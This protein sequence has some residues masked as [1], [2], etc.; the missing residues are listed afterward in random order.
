MLKLGLEWTTYYQVISEEFSISLCFHD[1]LGKIRFQCR[2]G[3]EEEI[4][5]KIRILNYKLK[6]S[7][8]TFHCN[9]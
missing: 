9:T 5:V 1:Y 6:K 7:A 2:L 4:P 3:T 8:K